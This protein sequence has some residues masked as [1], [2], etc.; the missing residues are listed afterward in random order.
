MSYGR[1]SWLY[2]SKFAPC[3]RLF[4]ALA[5]YKFTIIVRMMRSIIYKL[6]IIGYYMYNTLLIL[7]KM[8]HCTV[9]RKMAQIMFLFCPQCIK[10]THNSAFWGSALYY[11]IVF[12]TTVILRMMRFGSSIG[13][14]AD[15]NAA[16]W[17]GNRAQICF[18]VHNASNVCLFPSH[19][20]QHFE[21]QQ[22]TQLCNNQHTFA[23]VVNF[24]YH[25][26]HNSWIWKRDCY[27]LY[28]FV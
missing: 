22:Y 1:N 7:I 5:L 6:I 24:M 27:Q 17:G 10:F 8:L 28:I 11:P 25:T 9:G 14:I 21:D 2:E 4:Q 23:L 13:Y 19:T 26:S 15:Q 20:I 18:F 12:K 3:A 16:L